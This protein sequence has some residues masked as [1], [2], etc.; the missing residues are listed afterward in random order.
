MLT[1]IML[2][3]K[4]IV[5]NLTCLGTRRTQTVYLADGDKIMVFV[6]NLYLTSVRNSYENDQGKDCSPPLPPSQ[7]YYYPIFFC[8]IHFSFRGVFV[9][10]PHTFYL[11]YFLLCHPSYSKKFY[12]IPPTHS[13]FSQLFLLHSHSTLV[14]L[15]YFIH[16][17]HKS[18][19][20]FK[21][22]LIHVS[23]TKNKNKKKRR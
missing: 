21:N 11:F 6:M 5:D 22:F 8:Y 17:F 2:V 23:T 4:T 18:R 9:V 12:T 1:W 19:T 14:H 10:V 15:S 3:W 20:F 16:F 13:C 7:L